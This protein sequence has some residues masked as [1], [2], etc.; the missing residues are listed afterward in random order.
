MKILSYTLP[1][2]NRD[3]SLGRCLDIHLHK[4]NSLNKTKPLKIVKLPGDLY[5]MRKFKSFRVMLV[6]FNN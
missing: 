1:K 3:V 4:I 5:K 6:T 2:Y